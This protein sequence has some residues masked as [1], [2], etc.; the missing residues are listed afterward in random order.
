MAS[1]VLTLLWYVSTL[2]V[3][4]NRHEREVAFDASSRCKVNFEPQT[5]TAGRPG[6]TAE[7]GGFAGRLSRISVQRNLK[8]DSPRGRAVG[9]GNVLLL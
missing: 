9:R 2:A 1:E 8:G 3:C 4:I 6:H 5:V 7:G